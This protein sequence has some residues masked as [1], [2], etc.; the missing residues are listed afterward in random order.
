ML[1]VARLALRI[2]L[3]W[4]LVVACFAAR[5]GLVRKNDEVWGAANM[6]VKFA[7][8]S[9]VAAIII[10]T[11]LHPSGARGSMPS[12]H[13]AWGREHVEVLPAAYAPARQPVA[14]SRALAPRR[15]PSDADSSADH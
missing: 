15:R 10:A 1:R 4:T 13:D 5:A 6:I 12:L 9:A 8:V 7:S 11:G 14:P 2:I 3:R